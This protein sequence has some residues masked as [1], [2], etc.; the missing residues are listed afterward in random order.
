MSYMHKNKKW[1]KDSITISKT[2]LSK[3]PKDRYVMDLW[4]L[5]PE[6]NSSNTNYAYALDIIDHF[7]K[8]NESYLLNTKE[9]LEIFPYFKNFIKRHGIPKYI[10]TYNGK[11]FKNNLF[12]NFCDNNNIRFLH[13][14][15]YRPDS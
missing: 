9:S 5:P 2:I 3:G 10:I 13:G 8:Y 7:S 1:K 4:F 15:P 12:K 11:E 14:L 6:L